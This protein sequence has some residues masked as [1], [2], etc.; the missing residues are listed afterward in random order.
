MLVRLV[1]ASRA[2]ED[3]DEA[4]L[5]EILERSQDH[6]LQHGITGIL[7]SHESEKTFLQVIEGSRDAVNT[8]YGNIVR[9][10]R[11]QDLML[12]EYTEIRERRFPGWRMGRIDLNKVNRSI[13]LRYSERATL[14][15]YSMTGSGALALLEELAAGAAVVSRD[16][17]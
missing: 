17:H 11:H 7:C 16:R 8:L 2:V 12:L 1:Y 6:N 15:P 4:F 10:A 3:I 14:D 5:D 9:D 13:L